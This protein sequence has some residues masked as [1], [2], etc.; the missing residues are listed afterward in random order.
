MSGCNYRDQ[1]GPG[2]LASAK[3]MLAAQ[4]RGIAGLG[5]VALDK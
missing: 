2:E 5:R 3:Q 4:G 1:V